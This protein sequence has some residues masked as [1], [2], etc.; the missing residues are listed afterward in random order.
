MSRG[1]GD[2]FGVLL[3]A[4]VAGDGDSLGELWRRHQPSLLRYLRGRGCA[5]FEDV[6]SQVWIDVARGLPGFMG[7][8]L[9]FRRWL[10]T[11]AHHRHVDEVRRRDR[12]SRTEATEAR[13]RC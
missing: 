7:G 8:E 6:A 10:F 13:A 12:R 3:A 2:D 5:D 1:R 9:D 4:A 11:I